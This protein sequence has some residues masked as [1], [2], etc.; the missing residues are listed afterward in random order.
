MWLS[1][2]FQSLYENIWFSFIFQNP[3][4]NMHG[5]GYLL[6]SQS[7]METTIYFIWMFSSNIVYGYYINCWSKKGYL[8][9]IIPSSIGPLLAPVARGS[10]RPT[11]DRQVAHGRA[12]PTGPMLAR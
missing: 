10:G 1:F 3:Y 8:N 12:R 9:Y 6:F 5:C 7:Q 4:E 11:V 2:I